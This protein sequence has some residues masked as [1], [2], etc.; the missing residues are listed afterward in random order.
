MAM[1]MARLYTGSHDLLSLRNAYHGLSGQPAGQGGW[2]RAGSG[3]GA[4]ARQHAAA[5]CGPAC[6]MCTGPKRRPLSLS[7]CPPRRGHDG[8]AGAAHLEVPGAAGGWVWVLPRA[9]GGRAALHRAA[10]AATHARARVRR[11][12]KHWH[13]PHTPRRALECTTPSTPRPTAAATATTGPRTP[14]TWLISSR[15]PRR[16]RACRQCGLGQAA[17]RWCACGPPGLTAALLPAPPQLPISRTSN[18]GRLTG[19]YPIRAGRVAGFI[20]ETIQGVGGATPLADGYLPAAYKARRARW[21]LALLARAAAAVAG[22][23]GAALAPSLPSAPP[24]LPA[25]RL[26]ATR[27]GCASLTRCRPGLGAPA[28]RT[29]ASRTRWE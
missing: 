2:A 1:M 5:G 23:A 7:A 10:A 13:A 9:A 20:H 28:L 22:A 17:P 6:M 27:A 3:F 15:L 19:C 16:V 21:L 8:P 18:A 24:L 4:A 12:P 11:C 25:L 14:L 29:G 26:C